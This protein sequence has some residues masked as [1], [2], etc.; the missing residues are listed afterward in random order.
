MLAQFLAVCNMYDMVYYTHLTQPVGSST[1]TVQACTLDT[2]F[3]RIVPRLLFLSNTRDLLPLLEVG[4]YHTRRWTI[5]GEG[6][7]GEMRAYRYDRER[8]KKKEP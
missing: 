3:P 7:G 1:L 4:F 2:V 6:T 8:R 5:K